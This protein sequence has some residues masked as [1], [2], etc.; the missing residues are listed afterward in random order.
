MKIVIR[1]IEEASLSKIDLHEFAKE[2]SSDI[3]NFDKLFVIENL[4]K[5]ACSDR[6]LFIKESDLIKKISWMIGLDNK[7]YLYI[8]NKIKNEFGLK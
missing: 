1:A 5:V 3:D 7:D 2:V 8:S 6:E 4:F